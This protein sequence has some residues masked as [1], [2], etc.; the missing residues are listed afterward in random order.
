[1]PCPKCGKPSQD[2]GWGDYRVAGLCPICNNDER[3]KSRIE[4][5]NRIS[6]EYKRQQKEKE[7]ATTLAGQSKAWELD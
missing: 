7:D 1:M 4:E 5:I 2:I 6:E 3:I